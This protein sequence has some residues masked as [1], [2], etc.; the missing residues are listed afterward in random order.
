LYC[1][2]GHQILA[3][4]YG[5]KQVLFTIISLIVFPLVIL[6]TRRVVAACSDP[7]IAVR[8][9]FILLV[10]A[11]YYLVLKSL[12][13]LFSRDDYLPFSPLA[14]VLLIALLLALPGLV[15]SSGWNVDRIFRLLPLPGLVAL[16]ELAV[17]VH[18]RGLLSDDTRSET[19]MLRDLLELTTPADYVFDCKGETIFRRRCFRPIIETITQKRILYGLMPDTASQ[20]C[21]ETRTCVMATMLLDNLTSSTRQF[22]ERNYLPVADNLRVAGAKLRPS[23]TNS[24]HCYFNVVIPS[25]YKIVSADGNSSGTLDGTPYDGARF[26]A[27]GP[28]AFEPTSNSDNL[29]CVWAQAVDRNFT[30]FKRP[31]VSDK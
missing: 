4:L 14:F 16:A 18:T 20:Q 7:E 24:Q 3:R 31:A 6:V 15:K 29:F 30:P 13:P 2:F 5:K 19:E 21:I 23:I 1:V 26:L 10:T 11:S 8:R 17:L 27:A 12:W 9:V 25:Y 28:H 22:M